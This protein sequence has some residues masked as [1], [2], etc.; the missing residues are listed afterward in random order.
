[1]E[2]RAIVGESAR[3]ALR[4]EKK[5]RGERVEKTSVADNNSRS[6]SR[7]L[8]LPAT[9]YSREMERTAAGAIVSAAFCVSRIQYQRLAA[10]IYAGGPT[11][12]MVKKRGKKN[13]SIG[14]FE[15]PSQWALRKVSVSKTLQQF[16]HNWGD[17]I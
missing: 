13:A 10:S 17:V 14:T 1:M 3:F 12:W 16:G 5:F 7:L 2:H 9:R 8:L 4:G 15:A 6:G 11:K